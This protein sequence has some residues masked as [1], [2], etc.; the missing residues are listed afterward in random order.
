MLYVSL[1][2]SGAKLAQI[3]GVLLEEVVLYLLQRSGYRTVEEVG[4]DPTLSTCSAGLEVIGR[5]EHHQI[6]AI[7]DFLLSPPFSSPQRLLVEA[8]CYNEVRSIG[9][10]LVRNAVGVLKDVS[11]YWVPSGATRIVKKRW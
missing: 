1:H 7:A 2:Q 4:T 5:G 11:E 3:Q 9:L 10:P 6:D 8:K